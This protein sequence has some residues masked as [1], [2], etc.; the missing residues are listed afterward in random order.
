M[1]RCGFSGCFLS[2]SNALLLPT[3]RCRRGNKN[4]SHGYCTTHGRLACRYRR[5]RQ[6]YDDWTSCRRWEVCKGGFC[7][8]T[9]TARSRIHFIQREDCRYRIVHPA[10]ILLPAS[11]HLLPF[12]ARQQQLIS[13][14]HSSSG[15]S[16]PRSRSSISSSIASFLGRFDMR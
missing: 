15:S 12:N 8:R 10:S 6:T 11:P 16:F 1:S 3:G 5:C 7:G 13:K 9:F 14:H 4:L 2:A